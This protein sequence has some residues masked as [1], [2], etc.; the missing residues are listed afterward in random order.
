VSTANIEAFE[1]EI[2]AAVEPTL[3]EIRGEREKV[4]AL[5]KD[6]KSHFERGTAADDT[7]VQDLEARLDD[8]EARITEMAEAGRARA[9]EAARIEPRPSGPGDLFRGLFLKDADEL[10]R[11]RLEH[12]SEA[13]QRA[14]TS[15][16]TLSSAGA[17]NA[18]QEDQFLDWL[19]EEQAALSRVNIR[20]MVANQATLDE[21]VTG[22]RKLRAATEATTQ[23]VAD[24]FTVARRSLA[25]KETIWAEDLSYSFIE[26]NIERADIESHIAR[27]LARGFG[28]DHNDLFW[29]GDEDDSDEFLGI[30]DGLIDI[31]KADGSVVD[32]SAASDTKWTEIFNGALKGLPFAFQARADLAF[33]VPFS[34]TFAYADELSARATSLGDAVLTSGQAALRYFGIPVVG[35]PHLKSDEGVLSPLVNLIWGVQRGMTFETERAT[36]KRVIEYTMTARSDQNYSKSQ[37]VVLIDGIPA[38]LR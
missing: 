12:G 17:M 18:D 14:L 6:L 5:H 23:A 24:G 8:A 36:R 11:I 2:R 26:D 15:G 30:N 4:E 34:G 3:A 37:A 10:K 19:V 29:N 35:E 33:F 28:N 25:V 21:L 38:A 20:R 22:T 31:A 7:K 1:A 16:T 9:L 32:Y 13:L 27:N